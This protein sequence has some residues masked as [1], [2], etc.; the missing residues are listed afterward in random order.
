M[1]P[2]LSVR[3]N[4]VRRKNHKILPVMNLIKKEFVKNAV[5][6]SAVSL[7][8]SVVG[9]LFRAYASNRVGSEIMGLLQLILSVYY[10]ACT[11]ASSGVYVA[12]TRLCSETLARKDRKI[13]EILSRCLIYG[14]SFGI[15]AFLLLFFGAKWIA[16]HWLAFPE[17]EIPL[18]ILSFGLPFLSAANALQGF[19]LSLRKASYSTV[20]QVTEDLSKIGATVLLF[21]LYLDRGP[22]AALCAMVAGMAIGETVSCF[23]GYLLYR[24]K[25]TRLDFPNTRSGQGIF[26]EVVKIAIPCAFSGYLR[27]GIGMIESILVPRGL[28]AS[29][30]TPEQTLAAL[31]K[32]EGMALPILIFPATFLTV[33]SKLLVPEITAENAIGN[34]E[35]NIKTTHL[36]LKWTMTYGVF[37]GTLAAVF[38]KDLGRAIY[39]DNTCGTYLTYLAPI[40]PILYGDKVIDGIMKGYNRQLTTMKIN[41]ADTVFQTVGAWLLIPRTGIA[42]YVALFCIGATFN[43]T[44]SFLSLQKTCL[45]R[46]PIRDG[47]VKPLLISL[48]AT[49]PLKIIS[50]FVNCSVWIWIGVAI[51]L[52][53]L[54]FRFYS[55]QPKTEDTINKLSRKANS[56]TQEHRLQC[57]KQTIR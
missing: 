29:G 52:F 4:I 51:P 21:S 42:G 6:V 20:L 54:F 49:L 39:H 30:L 7:T 55:K 27:S 19:F 38:G 16:V 56:N 25:S 11:L 36:V 57:Q 33:V 24:K 43:F 47:V 32:F 28:G 26:T 53:L 48:A 9:V 13:G 23:C 46:F 37:V 14:L 10:P 3:T 35:N 8:M 2:F 34:K 17:A 1:I 44:L 41:L 5:A 50:R 12:S 40:V 15:G 18:K 22:N 45:I 31:G